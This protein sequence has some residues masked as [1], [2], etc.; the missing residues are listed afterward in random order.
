MR[1]AAT[2]L[3]ALAITSGIAGTPGILAAMVGAALAVASGELLGRS[4]FKLSVVVA[5]HAGALAVLWAATWALTH[6]E[7]LP[8]LLGPGIAL[9]IDVVVRFFAASVCVVSCFRAVAVR[10]P[11]AMALELL[12]L[13]AAVS[14]MFAAHRDAV[15]ERPLWLS[16]WAWRH[17]YDPTHVLIGF[18][19]TAVVVLAGLLIAESRSRISLASVLVL[20]LLALLAVSL[21]SVSDLRRPEVERDLG[22]TE[23]A[24]G[25]EPNPTP[26]GPA[27]GGTQ[28]RLDGGSSRGGGRDGGRDGGASERDGGRDGGA[29]QG[30]QGRDGGAG[31]SQGGQDQRGGQGRQGGQDQRPA[32]ERLDDQG[33]GPSQSPAPVAVVLLEDDYSPE[34]QAYYFRQ[35]VWSEYTGTRLVATHRVD[36]DLDVMRSFPTLATRVRST[37]PESGRMLVHARVALL[38]D[39]TQPFA[40]ESPVSFAPIQ[41]PN[42]A[43]FERAYRFESLAQTL[44]YRQLQGRRVGDPTWAPELREYY[45]RAPA[46]PRYAEL[47]RQIV[48]EL[49][50]AVR[51]DPF[52]KALAVKLWL[53]REVSYST[54]ARHAGV[55]DPAGD[56]LFGNR[57]GYCVH[58][59]HAAVYLWR[60]LGI[61]ARVGTGYHAPEDNRRG[62]TILIRSN[63]GHAWPELHVE[64]VGWVVLDIAP[65]RNLDPPSQPMD[66]DL[67]EL[68]GDMARQNPPEPLEEPDRGPLFPNLWPNLLVALLCVLIAS[69]LGL[70]G[71]KVWRRLAPRLGRGVDMPRVGYRLAL[72]LLC[73]AGIVREYGETRE[74]FS[75]RIQKV[76][77]AFR[78]LTAWNVAARLDDPAK[79]VEGRAELKADNWRVAL[80]A[81]KSQLSERTPRWRRVLGLLNPIS[82]FFSR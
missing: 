33:E 40:L 48:A 36:A 37:P 10:R 63:D 19:A 57:I 8:S 81:F 43:R 59:A 52:A 7:L 75:E 14:L 76:V 41:N 17:G 82:F 15:I 18:G 60:S 77:P 45:L 12:V 35:D 31:Q 66:E 71:V 80:S 62:S 74:A 3:A 25:E 16:D 39:H 72:D 11:T 2:A 64:G 69:L 4:R 70:Y 9:T 26:P 65:A 79:P 67:Q 23:E 44:P 32:S 34:S 13:A 53:D 20:P 58:F 56:M 73:E 50:P 68:L 1:A 47:A 6:F 54:K 42:P 78:Q 5:A 28:P 49:P 29:S 46:D 22:L 61:P 30:D 51:D 24:E 27:E 38:T 55:R 21:L